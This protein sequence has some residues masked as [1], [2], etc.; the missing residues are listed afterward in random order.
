MIVVYGQ[1]GDGPVLA[2]RV[3]MGMFATFWGQWSWAILEA[4]EA[5]PLVVGDMRVWT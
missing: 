2:R 1:K 4:T 3:D 5:N